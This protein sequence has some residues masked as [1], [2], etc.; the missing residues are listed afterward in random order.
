MQS[1]EG[2]HGEP[3]PFK[4]PAWGRKGC[5]LCPSAQLFAEEE[6]DFAAPFILLRCLFD[7]PS[8]SQQALVRQNY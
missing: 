3:V 8:L 4:L 5:G 2:E 1:R 7:P 6:M